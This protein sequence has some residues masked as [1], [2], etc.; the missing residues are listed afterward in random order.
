MGLLSLAATCEEDT[1]NALSTFDIL[2]TSVKNHDNSQISITIDW[3][4]V[5]SLP[6]QY[7][8]DH[9]LM[10]GTEDLSGNMWQ[11]D[12]AFV[13]KLTV[14]VVGEFE[15]LLKKEILQEPKTY[16]FHFLFPDRRIHIDCSHA[17]A[18]DFYQLDLSF[19]LSEVNNDVIIDEFNWNEK[20]LKGGM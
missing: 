13:E 19:R 9:T 6:L 8:E 4:N 17:G 11:N 1:C 12:H 10:Q 20:F 18:N 14:P 16:Q 7:F 15:L 3:T 2:N 5:S